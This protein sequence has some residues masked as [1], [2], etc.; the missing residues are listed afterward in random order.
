MMIHI[1][2]L[3]RNTPRAVGLSHIAN[4]FGDRR[5]NK[6]NVFKTINVRDIQG[7]KPRVVNAAS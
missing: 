4:T 5:I 6:L 2:V 1:F 7:H 3:K